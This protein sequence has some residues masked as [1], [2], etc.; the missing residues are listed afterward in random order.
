M[1]PVS[2][3]HPLQVAVPDGLDG[4]NALQHLLLA[5]GQVDQLPEALAL[6]H[7][8]TLQL[9][10]LLPQGDDLLTL[11]EATEIAVAVRSTD[12]GVAQVI[13]IRLGAKMFR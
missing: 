5:P 8:A 12:A 2:A 10:H 9:G 7:H 6:G 3:G 1:V 4:G 11:L 13:G